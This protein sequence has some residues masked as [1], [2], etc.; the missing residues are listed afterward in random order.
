MDLAAGA[1][2]PIHFHAG[3][4]TDLKRV[5]EALK[6]RLAFEKRETEVT[7]LVADVAAILVLLAAGLSA[8]W[9]GRI[10]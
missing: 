8:W 9:L 3:N 10:V 6:S 5:Y 7:A 4:G 2:A 1:S